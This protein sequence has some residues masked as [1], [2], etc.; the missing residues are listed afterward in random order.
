MARYGNN[1]LVFG[2]KKLT[3]QIGDE[4]VTITVKLYSLSGQP[5][6]FS[7]TFDSYYRGRLESCGAGVERY[8]EHFPELAPYFKWH[9]TGVDGPMHYQ[10]NAVFWFKKYLAGGDHDRYSNHS[11]EECLRFA[12]STAVWGTLEG[13]TLDELAEMSLGDFIKALSERFDD[14]MRAYEADMVRLFGVPAVNDALTHYSS[15]RKED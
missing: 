1:E 3:R 9:L 5:A 13:E 12:A 6:Y 14:L 7:A 10:A 8:A 11:A 2:E 15:L 4:K